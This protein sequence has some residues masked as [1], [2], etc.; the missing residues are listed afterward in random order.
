M[1]LLGMEFQVL[2]G[3]MVQS[4]PGIGVILHLK[5]KREGDFPDMPKIF[6]VKI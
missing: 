6:Q 4:I 2:N 3:D 5:R 1:I